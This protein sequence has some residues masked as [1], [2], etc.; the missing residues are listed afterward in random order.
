MTRPL[1]TRAEIVGILAGA[2]RPMH[3]RD[4]ATKLGVPEAA[5]ARLGEL[6]DQLCF[7]GSIQRIGKDRYRAP[8]TNER[9]SEAWE[10]I[11]T[12]N[13][14]GFGFVNAA[15]HDDV[16]IPPDAVGAAMHGDRVRI[17]VVNRS[18]RGLEGRILSIVAR[19]SARVAGIFRQRGKSAWLEP[20]DTRLRGPIVLNMVKA[21][22]NGSGKP[23]AG[24]SPTKERMP[25][26]GEAAIAEITRFPEYSDEAPEGR[27][28][29]ALGQSGNPNTEVAKILVREQIVEEHPVA[30]IQEAEAMAARMQRFDGAGRTDLRK[31]PL[32]TIDPVDA[33]DHDDAVWVEKHGE[34]YRVYVAI[35]DVAEYVTEGSALDA[36]ARARGCTIY[37]PDR[38]I[39]M[40]PSAL[41]ADLCSLLPDRERL[42]LC[43]IAEL[44]RSGVVESFEIVEGIMCSA[45]MLT[46]EGVALTLGFT[47]AGQRSHQAD[48]MKP[49]LR[50]LDELSK[51]LRKR[52]LANG[53]LDLDL[54]EPHVI[55]DKEVGSP[56]DVVRRAK[57]PGIKRAY[58]M[59]EE[60]MLLANELVATWLI[61]RKSLAIYRVHATPDPVKLERLA[62]VARRIGLEIAPEDLME[63]KGL[64]RW[65]RRID[66]HPKKQV[67]EMLTLRSL[68]QAVYDIV[69]IGH[70]GL[71]S[72]AYLHFTSPIRRYPDLVVHRL[73]KGLL[74]GGRACNTPDMVELVRESATQ[75]SQRERASME[76]EREVVDLYRTLLM[77][78]HVGETLTGIVTGVTGNGVYVALDAPFVDVLVRTDALGADSYELSDDELALVG[79][80]SGDRV[81]LGQRLIVQIEE[82]ALLRRIT[83]A[84]RVTGK[85]GGKS[86]PREKLK[87]PKRG[88]APERGP[89]RAPERGPKSRTNRP[90]TR[91]DVRAPATGGKKPAAPKHR[92]SGQRKPSKPSRTKRR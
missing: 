36:E 37:L 56:K 32:P 49:G 59:I 57:D 86:V 63:P 41:A 24:Q 84:R 62:Q 11:L 33:R 30:A 76:V 88:R 65:M 7:D 45:A 55:L 40:L 9:D 60:L 80:R 38:A 83:L 25:R 89:G 58:Q 46:Y 16:Y 28:I 22:G 85:G 50:V 2:E 69:N 64:G 78:S 17:A 29:A 82:A 47:E 5:Q 8:A 34:G 52:R 3:S 35:A 12:M 6:L 14:R 70:F 18:S 79:Q 19:R 53:A 15:G 13:Q 68:K 71:A 48:A 10:G 1:P 54:P 61:S 27:L 77:Q 87:D 66:E 31:V 26:D 75:S 21:T 42:C 51:K 91:P 39:P 74:R 44:D 23:D 73:V 90:L 92:E 72:D 4:V 20:D 43:V 81:E 67:L